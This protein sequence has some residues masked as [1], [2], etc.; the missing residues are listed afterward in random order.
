MEPFWL[1]YLTVRRRRL[2]VESTHMN[3]VH[4][5]GVKMAER[6]KMEHY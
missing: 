1:E 3:N 4:I 2:I 5:G 6:I